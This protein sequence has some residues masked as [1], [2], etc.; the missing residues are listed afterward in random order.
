MI[1]AALMAGAVSFLNGLPAKGEEAQ[2][3]KAQALLE[4]VKQHELDRQIALK[5]TEIDRLK[6][7]REK[8]QKDAAALQQTLDATAALVMES[9]GSL[10][11]LT[12]Q[13]KHLEQTL[14]LTLARIEAELKRAE[15][16]KNLNAAQNKSLGVMRKRIEEN[17]LRKR[18]RSAEMLMLANGKPVADESQSKEHL[19]VARLRKTLSAS[20]FKTSDEEK[21]AR[22]AVKQ[23][24]AKLQIA[25]STAA[26]AKRQADD[27]TSGATSAPALAPIAEKPQEA[28]AAPKAKPVVAPK[29][30]VIVPR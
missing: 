15:C 21:I 9:T 19:D 27:A 30:A 3:Q 1:A 14:K 7:D 29:A 28:K 17:D 18:L 2:P 16:L 12:A 13:R 24:C 22:D 4:T 8:S 5:Q 20:E 23:A 11:Q 10:E 6:E 25:D 26:K